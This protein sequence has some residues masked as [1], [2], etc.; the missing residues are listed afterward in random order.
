MIGRLIGRLYLNKRKQKD[1]DIY[2][3]AVTTMLVRYTN[4]D[5]VSF[6]NVVTM[7]SIL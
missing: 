1:V 3:K 7:Y 2:R 5:S 6:E 4:I